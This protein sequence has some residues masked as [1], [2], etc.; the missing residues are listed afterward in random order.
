MIGAIS[1]LKAVVVR[2]GGERVG[3]GRDAEGA[4]R[5][6]EKGTVSCR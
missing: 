5:V 4:A 1:S 3:D 2:G 6:R